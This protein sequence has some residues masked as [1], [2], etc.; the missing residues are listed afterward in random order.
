MWYIVVAAECFIILDQHQDTRE[1]VPQQ[2]AVEIP[3]SLTAN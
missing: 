1:L 2:R 3:Q